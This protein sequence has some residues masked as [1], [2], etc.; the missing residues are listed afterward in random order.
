MKKAL[1]SIILVVI[2][3]GLS[4]QEIELKGI[5]S[6]G[7][8]NKYKNN[9]GFGIGYNQFII[10]K[11]RLG[12]AVEFYMNNQAY[13]YNHTSA[14]DLSRYYQHINPGNSRISVKVNYSFCVICKQKSVLFIGPEIGLSWFRINE[15]YDQVVVTQQEDTLKGQYSSNYSL[16]NKPGIGFLAEYEL[17]EIILDR[18]S[19]SISVHPELTFCHSLSIKGLDEP[20]FAGWLNFSLGIKYSFIKNKRPAERK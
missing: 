14:T 20:A 5:Y 1:I 19:L 17:K 10:Q 9:F 8:F 15:K 12:V 18:I 4:G 7:T 11:Q 3:I 6:A 13:D 16:N 2:S